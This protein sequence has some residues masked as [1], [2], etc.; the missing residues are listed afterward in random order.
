MLGKLFNRN[1]LCMFMV[2]SCA[3]NAQE[4][5]NL[6]PNPGAEKIIKRSDFP[7]GLR[8]NRTIM[9]ENLPDGW[10]CSNANGYCSWGA[11]DKEFHS[12]EKSSFLKIENTKTQDNGAY[13]SVSLC[14]GNTDGY[15]G[16]NALAVQPGANSYYVSF[17]M[18]GNVPSLRAKLLEWEEGCMTLPKS[19]TDIVA[20]ASSSLA[21]DNSGTLK[22]LPEWTKYEGCFT[23]SPKTKNFAVILHV[24][25]KPEEVVP[26]QAFYVDDVEI[27]VQPPEKSKYEKLGFE[28]AW[29][30]KDMPLKLAQ[31]EEKIITVPMVPKKDGYRIVLKM[32]CRIQTAKSAG[33]NYNLGIYVDDSPLTSFTQLGE[34]R[35]INRHR[36]FHEGEK[37]TMMTLQDNN[38]LTI[39]NDDFERLEPRIKVDR[40]EKYWYLI[41]I[42]DLVTPL[43]NK[44][45][46]KLE[47]R[48]SFSTPG[49]ETGYAIIGDIEVG[50]VSE[51]ALNI[52]DDVQFTKRPS[53]KGIDIV[54]A[55]Y[56][57]VI[58]P[59]G[60]ME[61][62]IGDEKYFLDSYFSYPDAGM[63]KLSCGS[64]GENKQQR[65]I[66]I[67]QISENKFQINAQCKY[68]K[69]E[70]IITLDDMKISV[71]DNFRNLTNNVLG[72]KVDN[73]ISPNAPA[74]KIFLGGIDGSVGEHLCAENPTVFI[75]QK[76]SGLGFAAEDDA[77][78][79][80]L[81]LKVKDYSAHCLTD[82]F[83]LKPEETY[84]LRWTLYPRSKSPAEK[85]APLKPFAA[86][87]DYW[88]FI[89]QVRRDWNVNFIIPGNWG[90]DSN[91]KRQAFFGGLAWFRS[92][93]SFNR[94]CYT[95]TDEEYAAYCKK[96]MTNP[97]LK[98]IPGFEP[99]ELY[100]NESD[101]DKFKDSVII[102][103]LGTPVVNS[104][105]SDNRWI[106][107]EAKDQGYHIY[108][109]FIA[110]GNSLFKQKMEN[111]RFLLDDAGAGG[112][113]LDCFSYFRFLRYS[114]GEW[115]GR[116]VDIDP[117]KF[118]VTK[119][120]SDLAL[121]VSPAEEEMV[122]YVLG[123]GKYFIA[124][125]Q[126]VTRAMNNVRTVRFVE[127]WNNY[128]QVCPTAHLYTPIGLGYPGYD[129]K[130]VYG[131][132]VVTGEWILNDVKGV[133]SAG[134]LYYYRSVHIRDEEKYAYKALDLMYPFTPIEIHDGWLWGKE[135]IITMKSGVF[136]WHDKSQVKGYL[137]DKAGK[138]KPW[139]FKTFEIGKETV[140]PID[141]QSGEIAIL[142]RLN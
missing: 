131:R 41:D 104:D 30:L 49:T 134:C 63:N 135:R 37:Y 98:Y 133:L 127:T 105:D 61:I 85:E 86:T 18:K 138:Q 95:M 56:G 48:T 74:E 116:T 50:Y 31:R 108:S 119:K 82:N 33:W 64:E 10:G 70:R 93:G 117:E 69:L 35:V 118:T 3:L 73:I 75:K 97:A 26:G 94:K 129:A 28:S 102:N 126:P 47:N 46:L 67:T 96:E 24:Y 122:K 32:Q 5:V 90:G 81:K 92:N 137:F 42:N 34:F 114:Y 14:L 29:R 68:Y 139:N 110:K 112:L 109:G 87:P 23:I 65:E 58:A 83:G 115:D 111:A 27:K 2:V 128:S 8:A 60:G 44:T 12:G 107:K 36:V 136:G 71:Q 6:M 88:D 141:L 7:A 39:F 54:Q 11:S 101:F 77:Y 9:D 62:N 13:I 52:K 22:P 130:S 25:L 57:A 79:L 113:Y 106:P 121:V 53:V 132:G 76:K 15:N 40:S 4:P 89:N 43:L 103:K 51:K 91:G 124:N 125:T 55:G 72:I 142:E 21:L 99:W 59:E 140:T 120:Y 17:W 84:A 16:E 45:I 38:L 100:L 78:R 19:R 123:K 20:V 1:F 80:Q 66:K